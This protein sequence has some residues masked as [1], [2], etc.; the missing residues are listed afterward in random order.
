MVRAAVHDPAGIKWVRQLVQR[1]TPRYG[2][3]VRGVPGRR[4]RLTGFTARASGSAA[5]A[6][7]V[8]SGPAGP[9]PGGLAQAGNPNSAVMVYN[10]D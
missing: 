3:L 5:A 1:V 7:L 10:L 9:G 8:K 2:D 4:N 6:S